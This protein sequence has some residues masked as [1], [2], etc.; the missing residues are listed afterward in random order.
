[1]ALNLS[2]KQRQIVDFED[3][4]IL[5]KAGPGSG[6]TRVLIERIKSLLKKKK[7]Y[8]ILALTFSN[9]A[10]EEMKNR[11]EED[12]DIEEYIENVNVGTIHSFALDLVQHRGNLI[13]LRENLMIF[14]DNTDRQKMLRDVFYNDKELMAIL[15]K[16]EKPEK[17]L[18]ECLGVIADQKKRFISPEMYDGNEDFCRLYKQYN[19]YLLEQD[20]MDFDDI[21]F[22]AY[23]ILT[24]NPSVQ[25]MY[26]SLY[27][28]ICVDESQDLNYAQYE[29]IK[30]L[31][32]D[33]I[34]NIMFVGDA[35][36]SIYGFNGSNSELMTKY[37]VIDFKP[38]IF[39][40][41]E[42]FRS[43]KR[44]V[45]YA[46]RLENTDSIS[47][48]YYDGELKAYQ[49]VNE[50]MEARFVV[51][52]IYEICGNGHPDIEKKPEYEDFAIIARNRYALLN[53]EEMFKAENIPFYYKKNTNGIDSE[54]KYM[55]IFDL[56]LRIWSNKSDVV[57]LREL[58]GLLKKE[59]SVESKDG[60]Q[61]LFKG[62]V[63]EPILGTLQFVGDD[64]FDFGKV[65]RILKESIDN[66]DIEEDEK[67]LILS[68][69]EQ[70]HRHWRKYKA[71]IPSENR[72]LLSFRNCIS[73]GK[74]QDVSA[75]RGVAL[76]TA[77]MSKGLQFEVVFVVGLSE[78]T[79]PDYRAVSSGGK[80]MD[81]E[82]NNMFVAATRAK[83]LCYFSY[84]QYKKM[85]WGD[86]KFQR[87]SRFL[88]DVSIE[89][90]N[91]KAYLK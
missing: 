18:I 3:G 30:A 29:L 40:L 74:T 49:C 5:V 65:I 82:K 15:Q 70:W 78:G 72:T 11:L 28:Y 67:Y 50:E 22:Y 13:G 80:N 60:L 64:N 79:F 51:N 86:L 61:K 38:V 27:K 68:D 6:K 91:G 66:S 14:E 59:S 34:K 37:F 31:C 77:H 47:N 10:A 52:K 88:N 54:S 16:Q 8:K 53:I 81:Q 21:L 56:T 2:E 71:V 33:N 57:H 36:Q 12:K 42:N 73:L 44:I 62:S 85:P 9:L 26:A 32:G 19:Q 84:P 41:N 20:A 48:Y 23:R 75:D 83:R 76:L 4:A 25:K 39:E 63:Y 90:Y 17:F 35:N 45:E 24:E 43:S 46:N 89:K 55:R 1:M 58:C 87:A 69:I 7:R